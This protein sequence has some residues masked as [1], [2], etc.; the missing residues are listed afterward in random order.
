MEQEQV[1]IEQDATDIQLIDHCNLCRDITK[2]KEIKTS[3]ERYSE[4]V[5]I[6]FTLASRLRA[7]NIC[8]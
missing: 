1:I 2:T 8:K 5:K 3:K 6:N 7:N 4:A